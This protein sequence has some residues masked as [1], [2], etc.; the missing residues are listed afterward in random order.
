MKLFWPLREKCSGG[1]YAAEPQFEIEMED[2]VF[3]QLKKIYIENKFDKYSTEEE[4]GKVIRCILNFFE[5]EPHMI[6]I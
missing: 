4:V 2:D 1:C 6:L 3:N 5:D